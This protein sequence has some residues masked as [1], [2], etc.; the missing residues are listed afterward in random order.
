VL[1]VP[2]AVPRDVPAPLRAWRQ[3]GEGRAVALNARSGVALHELFT[4]RYFPTV[5]EAIAAVA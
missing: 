5:E 4:V 1:A 2:M 3:A